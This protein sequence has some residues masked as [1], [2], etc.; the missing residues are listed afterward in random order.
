M[1]VECGVAAVVVVGVEEVC[2]GCCALVVRGVGPLVGPLL[3]QGAVETFDFAVGL[4]PV[5]AG[6]LAGRADVGQGGFLGQAL[7]V[8]PG[9]VGQDAFDAGDALVVEERGRPGEEA[10]AGRDFLVRVDLA[11]GE[12]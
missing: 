8:G 1:P 5:G 7:A 2:Q 12:A 6:E 11:V 4:W 10:R 9:V 3:G